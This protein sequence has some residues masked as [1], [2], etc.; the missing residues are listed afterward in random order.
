M[1]Q[2]QGFRSGVSGSARPVFTAQHIYNREV[3]CSLSTG[4]F[5]NIVCVNSRAEYDLGSCFSVAY[6]LG[7][8]LNLRFIDW[9][10][11]QNLFT[12]IIAN[13]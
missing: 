13:S 10:T 8:T 6:F 7:G 12:S 1:V 3:R 4:S 9:V 2:E 11:L 5:N